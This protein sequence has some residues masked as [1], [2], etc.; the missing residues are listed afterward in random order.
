MARKS[1]AG[2]WS[3]YTV[4]VVDDSAEYLAATKLTLEREGHRVLTAASGPEALELLRTTP[5]DLVLLDYFMPGMTGEEVVEQLRRFNPYVQVILQTG[6]ASERPP[7][8]LLRRL[9]IQGYHDKSEGPDK[10]LLWTDVGLKAAYTVQL[11]YKSR[12]GLR[13]IL[14]VTPDLHRIQPLEDLLQGI[15]FQVAGLL[16]ASD[17]FIAV[18]PRAE[19]STA[20]DPRSLPDH[21]FLAMMEGSDLVIRA[22]TGRFRAQD[23]LDSSLDADRLGRVCRTVQRGSI[24]LGDDA[25]IVPL[26]VGESVLGVVYLDRAAR[27]D[28]DA[29]LLGLLA[30]QAA[31]ALQNAQLYQ[32]ATVDPL[33]GLYVRRFL[34]QW[35]GRELRSALRSEQPLSLVML[36]LD[37]FKQ[38]NDAAGHIV[39]DKALALVGK[40]L[41]EATRD[42]DLAARYGGDELTLVLP[43]TPAEGA[44]AVCERVLRLLDDASVEGPNGP[45]S[46]RV[47]IGCASLPGSAF[48][49]SEIPR[50]VPPEYFSALGRALVAAADDG[51]YA[52]KRAGGHCASLPVPIDWPAFGAKPLECWA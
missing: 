33:T 10:L 3:G 42:S 6:Y 50:P 19:R 43:N 36:D 40:V 25:T 16:G 9:D 20:P 35:L 46:V 51:V 37:R 34:E 24:E 17:S 49:A 52:A 5:V 2:R 4:A 7:R 32:M 18:V 48:G 29:E 13:Y 11:L 22:A 45:V 41:R 39:G 26:R 21:G 8:D 27:R 1:K 23:R 14:D 31:V 38:I 15:L 47:S 44:A 30:N 28:G 12:Q